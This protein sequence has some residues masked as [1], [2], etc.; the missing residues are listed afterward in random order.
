MKNS[1][2]IQQIS[3]TGNFDSN[4]ISRQYKPNLMAK[5]MQIYFD[6][7]KLRQSETA[8]QL[9]YSSSTL[10]RN[11]NDINKLSPYR[12]LLNITK[13]R[14]IKTSKTYFDNDSHRD[15][16]VKRPRLTSNDLKPTS[17]DSIRNKKKQIERLCKYWK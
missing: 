8:N 10:Q 13:K 1:F 4:L 6:N 15:P 16:D 17:N 7:P 9:G 11:R 14:R 12:I 3:E 2:P 5:F